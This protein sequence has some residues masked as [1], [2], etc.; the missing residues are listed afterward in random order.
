MTD[1]L[2]CA[3]KK[4]EVGQWICSIASSQFNNVGLDPS[5]LSVEEESDPSVEEGLLLKRASALIG[6][7]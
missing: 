2:A 1:L 3:R 7:P 5:D 4:E 6:K